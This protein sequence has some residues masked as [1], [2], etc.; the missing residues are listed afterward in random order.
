[1]NHQYTIDQDV[2]CAVCRKNYAVT[3]VD[4]EKRDYPICLKCAAKQKDEGILKPIKE[5]VERAM[6][7]ESR[8]IKK[9]GTERLKYEFTP[10]ERQALGQ[11]MAE[12]QEAIN[13]ADDELKTIREQFKAKI[14]EHE[15]IRD[16]CTSK[17]MSGYEM[18]NYAVERIYSFEANLVMTV[19]LD[20][21][22]TVG[23]RIMTA[24][25]RQMALEFEPK[26]AA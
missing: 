19:R 16:G 22:E 24:D 23:E 11:Q 6:E 15:A 26:D 18:R 8:I 1:M 4:G 9:R 5:V 14:A 12:A 21:G 7:H 10:E 13:R 17:I 25:E 2:K 20:T 3:E